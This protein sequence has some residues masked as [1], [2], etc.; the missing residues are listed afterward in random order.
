LLVSHEEIDPTSRELLKSFPNG[1]NHDESTT[2]D[3]FTPLVFL[4]RTIVAPCGYRLVF[5]T[6]STT[7]KCGA[8]PTVG[9]PRIRA[10]L[11]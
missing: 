4:T 11:E 6:R 5:T 7:A 2:G 10:R 8:V 3:E 9:I 1:D